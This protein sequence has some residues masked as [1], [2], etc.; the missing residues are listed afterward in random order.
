M[1]SPVGIRPICFVLTAPVFA[2][3]ASLPLHAAGAQS[4]IAAAVSDNNRTTI[5]HTIS[6]RAKRATDLGQASASRRLDAVTL[7]FNMTAAQQADLNQLLADQQ[8]PNSP[9]YHQWLTPAQFNARFGLSSA[10]LAKVTS[11]L[12]GKGL[13]IVASSPTDVTVSG[14]VPQI[15]QAFGTSIHAMSENGEQHISNISDPQLPAAIAN[16]VTGITGLND[17]KPK[18]RARVAHPQFTSSVSGSHYIAPGDFY[19][20]YDVDSSLRSSSTGGAGISIAVV[21]QTDISTTDVAN[22]RNASGLSSNLPTIVQVPGLYVAGISADDYD[23]AALDVEWSGAVAPNASI[24]FVTVGPP[25]NGATVTDALSYAI[26]NNVAPIISISYG[27]C[28]ANWGQSA[29]NSINQKLQQANAQGITVVGP[30]GDSGATDCDVSP[31]ADFGLAV[32]FPASSPYVTAAG[33]TMFN[34]GSATG[35]T[36]YWNSNGSS[37]T[38]NAGSA[39]SY[40]PEAVWN[41][42]SSNSSSL[43]AGGGGVSAYFTKPTWQVGNGVPADSA[44]DVPDVSFTSAAA[45]DGYLF[46]ATKG[47]SDSATSCSNGFRD[48]SSNLNIVGGTSAAAPTLAAVFA[49]LEQQLGGGSAGMIG[50]ANPKIYGLANSTYY[51]NVF[52]DTNTGNNNSPCNQGTPNCANGGSI[53]YSATTGYDLATGWGS[54][55]VSNFVSK[56]SL[57]SPAGTS[58]GSSSTTLA[59]SN[60]SVTTSA[61]TCSNSSGSIPLSIKVSNGSSGSLGVPTG[62]VQILVDGAAVTGINTATLSNGSASFTVNTSSLSS[63]GHTVVAVYGGDGTYAPSNGSLYV[64][65]TSSSQKDFALTSCTATASA[66]SGSSASALTFTLTPANG[67][68]GSVKLTAYVTAYQLSGNVSTVNYPSYVFNPA[69]VT[70]SG[71]SPVS[72]SLV[73]NAFQSSSG[74]T[75]LSARNAHPAS[76]GLPWTL[77]GSGVSLACVILFTL[78]RRR[79]W[80]ALLALLVSVAAISVSGCGSSSSS[81][82]SSSGNNSNGQTNATRGIYTVNVTAVSGSAVHTSVVTFTVN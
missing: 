20:I 69:T 46:C 55:D 70:I 14:T 36:S 24:K 71:N 73:L 76:L 27:N 21:G 19:T 10:D 4:R 26:S 22:F 38:N 18:A 57:V 41:E 25:R 13:T 50:N 16:V 33:G 64:D 15:E 72:A 62:T 53:G 56:W 42:S 17:F 35:S 49:L 81:S 5:A 28:E 78:P 82:S 8:N 34:E 47:S 23:E 67:F 48:A 31:P 44:R 79:R 9:S 2:A 37:S 6:G 75:A 63:G 80:G 66:S 60:V 29:M 65:I 40:I 58:S 51:N 7:H 61:Q 39:I 45:H 12:S 68:T 11:W 54:L 1:Q 59:I 74:G 32:D 52:H 3:I 43:S 77:A 30:A